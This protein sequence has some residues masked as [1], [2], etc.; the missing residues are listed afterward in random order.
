MTTLHPI[1]RGDPLSKLAQ[2]YQT[3]VTAL[4]KA[5]N[6]AAPHLIIANKSWR[7]PDGFDDKPLRAGTATTSARK[8]TGDSTTSRAEGSGRP[9]PGKGGGGSEGLAD[10]AKKSAKEMGAAVTSQKRNDEKTKQVGSSKNS[11]HYTGNKGAFAVD[12]DASGK[13]GDKLAK[14]IAKKYGIPE[15]NIG[16]YDKHTVEIDGKKYAL[17]LLWKVSN[18]DDH[19]HLGIRHVG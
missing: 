18:H 10:A 7:I 19:V 15:R 12:F 13:K 2:K 1:Q 14:A 17:Q 6:L 5:N 9:K 4:A 11:D 8:T 3:S 16:T